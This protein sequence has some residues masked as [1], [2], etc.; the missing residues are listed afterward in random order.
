M[1]GKQQKLESVGAKVIPA[2]HL[3]QMM[4]EVISLREQ[5]AQCMDRLRFAI[6][7]VRGV[8]KSLICIRPV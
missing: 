5:V 1:T 6:E 4:S 3:K 8:R 2:N 7:I